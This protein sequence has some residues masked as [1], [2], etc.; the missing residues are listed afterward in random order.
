LPLAPAS[1]RH[2][3]LRAYFAALIG[4]F[5]LVAGAGA[6][7][8]H[9]QTDRDVRAEARRDASFA[10]TAAAAELADSIASLRPTVSGLA[11]SPGVAQALTDP[12]GCSLSY[13]ATAGPVQDRGHID[14]VRADGTPMCSSRTRA[15]GE[16]AALYA[17][18]PWLARARTRRQV[19]AP[20]V[21]PASGHHVAVFTAP[22][23]GGGTVAAFFD[24][25]AVGS[26]LAARYG[27]SRGAEF[28]LARGG[29]RTILARSLAPGRWIGSSLAAHGFPAAAASFE[30]RDLDGTERLYAQVKVPGIDW[31]LTVGEEKAAALAAQSRLER[32]QLLIIAAGLLTFLAAAGAVHRRLARPI[33]QLG[34]ELRA[35]AQAECVVPVRVPT[36]CPQEVRSLA[37]DVN[38]L[39]ASIAHGL[40]AREEAASALARSEQTY[41]Q[42][43]ESH[44]AAMFV[45]D[46]QS[47][48]FVAVN[49]AAVATYAYTREEFL[50][51]SI[52]DIRAIEDRETI[53][54]AAADGDR[55]PG[56]VWRHVRKDGTIIEAA[57]S[58]SEIE[59]EQRPAILV[60]AQD[61]TEQKHLQRQLQQIYKMEAVGKLAGGIAHD[62]NNLLIVISGFSSLAQ[63]NLDGS[64]ACAKDYIGE[65]QRAADRASDLTRQLL[66]YSRR[67]VLKK[68]SLDLNRVVSDSEALLSRVIGEDVVVTTDLAPDLGRVL[69]DEGQLSQVLVN[70][71]VNARDAM[72]GGGRLTISTRNTVLDETAAGRLWGAPRGDYVVLEVADTGTGMDAE[73]KEH[74]FEPFF[75]TKAAGSGTG[76]GLSTVFGIVKQSDG[77][78]EADTELGVG[79]RFIVYLPRNETPGVAWEPAA[80]ASALGGTETIL[81]VEDEPTVRALIEEMLTMRGYTVLPAAGPAEALRLSRDNH[82]DAVVTDVVMPAM[83]GRDLVDELRRRKPELRALFTSGYTSDAVIER[84]V[85]E[86]EVAFVQK[87]FSADEL[88]ARLRQLLDG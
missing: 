63:D 83:N 3:S 85:A 41:R 31:T 69:A 12:T 28:L 88:A 37:D 5:V 77:Y 18:S 76:L 80:A 75:T 34:G 64:A 54:E 81:V 15:A 23:A 16:P 11:A 40:Q 71:A 10:A 47:L 44:P 49:D 87:P 24:L 4:V 25:T 6:A 19:A 60:L 9:I 79:T 43:F 65:V 29:R 52:D 84:G 82:V 20:V 70:L 45:F 72:P 56:G 68:E 13:T 57:V 51:M 8:V 73:T 50:S 42:L 53:R 38:M 59:F 62:F 30:R 46:P 2:W 78:I 21:D 27:G 22:V 33:A 35:S 32:R 67:Q 66:A 86:E 55:I 39:I 14:I 7:Y 17:G 74:L 48:R 26:H 1:D 36:A 61:V 58:S